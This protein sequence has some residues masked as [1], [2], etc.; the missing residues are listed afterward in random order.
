MLTKYQMSNLAIISNQYNPRQP[1]AIPI[2]LQM[3]NLAGIGLVQ[4]L[5]GFVSLGNCA[6]TIPNTSKTPQSE[7]IIRGP[8]S[9]SQLGSVAQSQSD[10]LSKASKKRR[11][12]FAPTTIIYPFFGPHN[13]KLPKVC[14]LRCLEFLDGKAL[15]AISVVNSLWCKAAMDDALWE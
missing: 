1:S 6:G 5:N 10:S 15:Y 9:I 7:Y 12:R 11:I 14:A 8:S 13:P 2:Q 4:T 3:Q